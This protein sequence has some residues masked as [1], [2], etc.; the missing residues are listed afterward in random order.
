[1]TIGVFGAIAQVD[2]RRLLSFHIISQIGYLVMALGLFTVS[3]MAGLVYFLVH[4]SIAKSTLFLVGG[5]VHRLQDS[6][7]LRRLGGLYPVR[8]LLAGFF[9]VGAMSLAGVPPFSGFV[10]K[11]ALIEAG[12]EIGQGLIIAV[13]LAV[14][15]LTLYSMLKIWNEAFWKPSP[16]AV[17]V[18]PI[19]AA[20][21]AADPDREGTS[22]ADG[23]QS[24]A[25]DGRAVPGAGR[26]LGPLL[27][28]P[29][30]AL[31]A[32]SIAL[33]IWAGPAFDL[34]D[35]AA[36]QLLDPAG[37]IQAVLGVAP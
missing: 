24:P 32:C 4:V 15:L 6:Y 2:M 22:G 13:A 35:R 18:G 36:R 20:D 14:S 9:L 10:A 11:L 26:R 34:V 27:V 30:A 23:V 16:A 37:Y 17:E 29:I 28:G 3:A 8:P 19:P 21:A 25:A 31:V 12:L 5:A 7:D 33:T 1:M